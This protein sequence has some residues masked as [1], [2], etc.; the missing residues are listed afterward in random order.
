M[1]KGTKLFAVRIAPDMQARID[2]TIQ[3]RNLWTRGED[4]SFSDFIRVAIEEKI[5]KMERSRR[6][7]PGRG[8]AS[9][10]IQVEEVVEVLTGEDR[11]LVY[12]GENPAATS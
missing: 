10:P 11:S 9:D 5:R 2:E 6:R 12:R 3:R 1:S 8:S 7:V 4:W